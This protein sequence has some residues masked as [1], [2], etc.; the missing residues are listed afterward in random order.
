MP[1]THRCC[2]ICICI[3]VYVSNITLKCIY[4]RWSRRGVPCLCFIISVCNH[5]SPVTKHLYFMQHQHPK[6]CP[7]V[8]QCCLVDADQVTKTQFFTRIFNR[9]SLGQCWQLW[10]TA[11]IQTLVWISTHKNTEV[12]QPLVV[13]KASKQK[14]DGRFMQDNINSICCCRN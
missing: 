12:C 11:M 1:A 7:E 13:C 4:A 6:V 5:T 2:T 8:N 10:I 3:L 9:G 14:Y